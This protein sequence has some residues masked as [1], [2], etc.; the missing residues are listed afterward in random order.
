MCYARDELETLRP[1]SR[2]R[3]GRLAPASV[4]VFHPEPLGKAYGP[5]RVVSAPLQT[6]AL[7]RLVSIMG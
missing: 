5:G 3:Q 6:R 1:E 2:I 7:L 4:R